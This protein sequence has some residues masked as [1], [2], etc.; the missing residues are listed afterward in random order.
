MSCVPLCKFRTIN[1]TCSSTLLLSAWLADLSEP[2]H[3]Y[4]DCNC[5]VLSPFKGASA[6]HSEYQV[7]STSETRRQFLKWT[8]RVLIQREECIQSNDRYLIQE[9]QYGSNVHHQEYWKS[10]QISFLFRLHCSSV[11]SVFWDSYNP[12][13]PACICTSIH[14]HY[15][16]GFIASVYRLHRFIASQF[17]DVLSVWLCRIIWA[18]SREGKSFMVLKLFLRQSFMGK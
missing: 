7:L 18:G 8:D 12:S 14:I 16:L 10:M 2:I 9:T 17:I 13:W 11:K 15:W 1:V 6:L 5:K 4:G 3:V